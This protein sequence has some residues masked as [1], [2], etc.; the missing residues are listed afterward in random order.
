MVCTIGWFLVSALGESVKLRRGA[1]LNKFDLC[2]NNQTKPVLSGTAAR[3]GD[4]LDRT[5]CVKYRGGRAAQVSPT[6]GV[7]RHGREGRAARNGSKERVSAG[8][9]RLPRIV[10]RWGS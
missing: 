1:H 5:R 2:D 9:G 6:A 3:A 8:S 4:L 10:S 7:R